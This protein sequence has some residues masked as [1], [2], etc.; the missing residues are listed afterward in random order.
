MITNGQCEAMLRRTRLG[1]DFVLHPGFLCAGGEEGNF[2]ITLTF[3]KGK[4]TNL[5]KYFMQ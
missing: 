5:V 1:S 4:A 3:L 2:T